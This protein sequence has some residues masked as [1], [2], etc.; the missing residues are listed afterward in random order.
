MK[1]LN[2]KGNIYVYLNWPIILAIYLIVA[3]T[4]VYFVDKNAGLVM[5]LFTFFYILFALY[6]RLVKFNYLNS[7]LMKIA[8]QVAEKQ[9]LYYDKM[10]S[11]HA[12]LDGDGRILWANDAFLSISNK[13]LVGK[14]IKEYFVELNSDILM[15]ISEE[16]VDLLTSFENR[17]YRAHLRQVSLDSNQKKY[18]IYDEND[19]LTMLFLSDETDYY[20]L[21][22]EF[23]DNKQV[24]G[25]IYIDN[26]YEIAE[27]MEDSKASMLIA[28]VDR[29]LTRYISYNTGVIKKLEKDKYFFVTTKKA[30]EEM[31]EARF[32]ILDQTKEI[33]GGDNIPL[34]LSIGVGYEGKSVESNHDLARVAID[35]ALGRGGDQAVVKKGQETYFYGGKSASA[36]TN[37]RVRSR[38]KATSFREI[39]DTKDQI[40]IMGH[41]NGDFDSFGASVGAYIMAKQLGKDA[42]IVINSLTNAVEEMKNKYVESDNYSKDM[43]IS[44]DE[45]LSISDSETLLIIVDHN[46]S[47][48]SDEKRLFDKGLDIVVFDHH[49]VGKN[50]INDAI[51]SYIDA[52]ASST[53]EL[54]TDV[55]IYFDDRAKIR[56]LEGDTMLAGMVV[57]TQY[58]T[59]QTSA[60]TFEAAAF[61]RKKGADSDRV[62]KLLRVDADFEMLKNQVVS[63]TEY[64]KKVYAIAKIENASSN[65]ELSVAKAEIANELVGI[66]GIKASFVITKEDDKY[67]ISSR[68]MD[69]VNV[70]LLMEKLGGGG[71]RSSAGADI[72]AKSYDEVIDAIKGVI[73]EAE[74]EEGD[75]E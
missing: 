59:Y 13:I 53:C 31:M 62:R 30:I 25:F 6:L 47:K 41:E 75:S 35:M 4:V 65:I 19:K 73:D 50:S 2:S 10:D 71:H 3:V 66:K 56:P 34:T 51:L 69:D 61:L 40:L 43:F 22:Q 55:M 60:K 7:S 64:Y 29:K 8:E 20:D 74:K 9:K 24:T 23:D 36:T 70:Q 45:A 17:K 46:T 1:K 57:D 28:M 33:I 58:F 27:S 38:V 21:K 18:K 12:V 72:V 67:M 68:S 16:K 42:H 14:N 49:R 37:V 32:S 5:A 48:I 44:G 11:P 63:E 52:G 54:I 15:S 26:F 39:L